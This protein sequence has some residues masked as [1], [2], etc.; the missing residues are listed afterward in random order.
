MNLAASGPAT[1]RAQGA[2]D[3]FI[4]VL[5]LLEARYVYPNL[6]AL[7]VML[8]PSVMLEAVFA[9]DWR[10]QWQQILRMLLAS[11]LGLMLGGIPPA[12]AAVAAL[13][14]G[15]QAVMGGAALKKL[16]PGGLYLTTPDAVLKLGIVAT[17][18]A[19]LFSLIFTVFRL[20]VQQPGGAFGAMSELSSLSGLLEAKAFRWVLPN[21][22]GIVIATPL[23]LG[24]LGDRPFHLSSQLSF[25][26]VAGYVS[27]AAL[28][29]LVFLSDGHTY[30]FFVCPALV[31]VSVSLGIR[32]TAAAHLLSIL[33]ATVAVAFGNGPADVLAIAP[34][35]RYLFIE[36][37]Y[38]CCYGCL[39]PIAASMEA[40]RR[41][42]QELAQT[43][44]FT[45]EI[46]HNMQEVV[47][48]TDARGRWTFLNPALEAMTGFTVAETLEG[49]GPTVFDLGDIVE[50]LVQSERSRGA[51]PDELRTHRSFARRDGEVREADISIRRITTPNG[52]F[53]G[54]AG[55][56][57]DVSDQRRYVVALEASEQRFRQLC[58]TSPIG[59]LRCD[60]H[61]LITYVN[62]RIELLVM[63]PASAIVGKLWSEVLG[64]A[65]TQAIEQINH[66][67]MTPGAVFENE[68][69]Y[70][71][72]SG[73]KR[74]LTFT[75]TGEFENGSRLSGY[76]A[77][78][79]DVTQRKASDVELANRTRELRLVTENIND[80]VFRIGLDGHCL[81]VT[82]SVRQVLGYDPN[83]LLGVP[84]LIRIHPDDIG[85]V[86]T[87]FDKLLQ[88][89]V[90]NLSVAYRALPAKTETEY[91]WLEA[92]CRLL[93]TRKGAPHEIVASVRDITA[94]KLLETD[95][96]EA[97]HRA[98][99][100]A[101][102]KS[103]FLANLSH[104][105][106]TPMNCVIGLSELLLD[107]PLDDTSRNYVRLISESGATM[108]K[109]LNDI[110]DIAKIDAGRLQLSAEPFDLHDCLADCMSLMTASA[111]GKRLALDLDIAPDVPRSIVG[112]SLRLRQIL[113]N[114]IGNAVK[115]TETG[116]IRLSARTE[117]DQLVIAVDDTGIGIS[118]A[119]QAKVFED[120]G[121]G[122][123]GIAAA[124]GG[125]GL[126]LPI[127]RRIAEAMGG[128]LTLTSELG[129][130]TSLVLRIKL[131]LPDAP[132]VSTTLPAQAPFLP[133]LAS[134]RVLVAED[135]RTNQLILTAMLEKLGHRVTLAQ[136]GEEAIA[137]VHEAIAADQP[138]GVVLMDIQMPGMDGMTATRLLRESGITP[139]MLP[140]IAVTANGYQE[141]I[142]L[143][144]AAGMQGHL[145]KPVRS[146]EI[147]AELARV[148]NQDASRL[149][150]V[151]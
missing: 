68:I 108:M 135:G 84:M 150:F 93:R 57:R 56:I 29:A 60:R 142:D 9:L 4:I 43:L 134:M 146:A 17:V 102:A 89:K 72:R 88:G 41:L 141:S 14:A 92:N 73:L 13:L 97:R 15:L 119:T 107:H 77:A 24:L 10:T 136:T 140:I 61:G 3:A 95:L 64:L 149:H 115:F 23:F 147:A 58:D 75:A 46:L 118:H 122:E 32:D 37:A 48:R 96:I 151:R 22:I 59:I 94:R 16:A 11:L 133:R 25:R 50:A 12:N 138:F 20:S 145:V 74:W 39:L 82:P 8:V 42:E 124:Y 69:N 137:M 67:L 105:I 112:D 120:F 52:R 110:L 7:T 86:R 87:G 127:S 148:A 83:A 34:E 117:G 66:T 116:Q 111:V 6:D 2:R 45:S 71:D 40:R 123:E 70:I 63:A 91:R 65:N 62:Q 126:G 21:A 113:A 131:T 1:N 121:Q 18:I 114:L 33:I 139:R 53:E 27:V 132:T 144:L 129:V 35:G 30:I 104:E 51:D 100:A 128:T 36:T 55:S 5:S 44:A 19:P 49:S 99:Q 130:G 80:M 98:E 79:T 101:A 31:W 143:C 76:I 85:A 28:T 54:I 106:R 125:T 103:T 26:R 109:L 47:F 90:D 38:L 78:V 81:Y